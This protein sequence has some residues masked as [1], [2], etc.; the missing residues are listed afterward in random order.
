MAEYKL[1]SREKTPGGITLAVS[2]CD[3]KLVVPEE[4]V[5][6]RNLVVGVCLNERQLEQL[7]AESHRHHCDQSAA[8]SLAM[9]EHS[10]GELMVKLRRKGHAKEIIAEVLKKYIAMGA[11]DDSRYAHMIGRSLVERRPCGQAYLCAYLQRRFVERSLAQETAHMLLAG[12]DETDRAEA[13]LRQRW[14]RLRE[15]ELETARR[16]AYNYLARRG[17]SYQAVKA[18]FERL[19]NDQNEE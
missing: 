5:L 6:Q 7:V 3:E 12:Q 9:R 11:L 19:E 8:R 16:K 4:F 14:H 15:F 13:A 1:L 18:A 17:F 10:R 2:G